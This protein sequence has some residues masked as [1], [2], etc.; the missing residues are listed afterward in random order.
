MSSRKRGIT[1]SR[2]GGTRRK[3]S[4]EETDNIEVVCRLCP[5]SGSTPSL[6]AVDETAVQ[7]VLP[8]AQY[9]REN[10]PQVEKIFGFGR[11]FSENDGQATVFERTSM[12]L[13][14]NMLKGQNSLLFTYGVTG[15]GKTYTMTGKPTENDTGLLPRTLDVIFN[16]INNRWVLLPFFSKTC[17]LFQRRQVHFLPG[18][19]EHVRDPLHTWR[20][21]ETSPARERTSQHES[22]DHRS[23]LRGDKAVRVQWRYGVRGFCKLRGDLQQLLLWFAGGLEDG[24][25]RCEIFA[26]LIETILTTSQFQNL[27]ETWTPPGPSAASLCR[28]R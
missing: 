24:V 6:I 26:L 7:T 3:K 9:R 15:S 18:C 23:I 21:H 11:V 12:D 1:P 4:F 2:E 14:L 22:R 16:S 17:W 19:I 8:P 25:S 10:A 28:W 13:I 5:Y 20:S 27:D